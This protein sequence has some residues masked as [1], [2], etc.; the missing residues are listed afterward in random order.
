[1]AATE[2]E[3]VGIIVAPWGIEADHPRNSDLLLQCI[4]GQRLRSALDGMKPAKDAK[5][6]E[7]YVPIDQ[8][9]HLAACPKVPGQQLHV[10][11][12]KCTYVIID[13]LRDNE[14]VLTKLSR[15]MASN[16]GMKSDG[17]LNGMPKI[18]GKL[19]I[20]QMKSLN[21]EMLH[22]V[23][24]GEARVVGKSRAPDLDDIEGLPGYFLLNPGSHNIGT[25]QPRYEKDFPEWID[26]LSHSGG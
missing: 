4:A 26:R 12:E 25:T 13:P 23:N 24:A 18:E 1:M 20:H 22:L 15:F 17:K 7:E 2:T 8:S 9:K 5:T 3:P 16:S 14:A 6:G 10:N 11:P 21:R 19:D